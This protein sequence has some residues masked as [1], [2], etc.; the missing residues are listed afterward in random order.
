METEGLLMRLSKPSPGFDLINFSLIREYILAA[1]FLII[2]GELAIRGSA[3]F[4][5]LLSGKILSCSK[6]FL[7]LQLHENRVGHEL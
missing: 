3:Y 2:R 6:F 7:E 1:T 5:S 4:L